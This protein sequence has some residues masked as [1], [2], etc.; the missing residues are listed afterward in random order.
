[1]VVLNQCCSVTGIQ[2]WGKHILGRKASCL[3]K[4]NA[5]VTDDQPIIA[6]W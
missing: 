6:P 1:M 2:G 4:D 5:D 3:E